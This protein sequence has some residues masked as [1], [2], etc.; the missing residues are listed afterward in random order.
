MNRFPWKTSL[1]GALMAFGCGDSQE[2]AQAAD[3]SPGEAEVHAGQTYCVY[4]GPIIETRFDCPE[5]APVQHVLEGMIIC[6]Q[7]ETLP[8]LPGWQTVEPICE[9]GFEDHCADTSAGFRPATD[10]ADDLATLLWQD[11]PDQELLTA[12][13]NGA[14]NT[15]S[16]V[17][18]QV[19]R[20][21]ADPRSKA[22]LSPFWT[23]YLQLQQ[24]EAGAAGATAF[25]AALAG[26]MLTSTLDTIHHITITNAADTRDL[27]TSREVIVEQDVGAIMGLSGLSTTPTLTTI[28][29]TEDRSGVLSHPAFLVGQTDMN[30]ARI[31]ITGRGIAIRSMLCQDLPP[32]PDV[33]TIP[34]TAT[35]GS[36]RSR[37][38]QVT[39]DP[40]CMGCHALVDFPSFALEGFDATGQERTL[41]NGFSIDKSGELDSA[42]L[43]GAAD[44]GVAMHDDSKLA[45]CMTKKWL[46]FIVNSDIDTPVIDED[47]LSQALVVRWEAADYRLDRLIKDIL[48]SDAFLMVP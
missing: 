8:P 35:T 29:L 9:Y 21:L 33:V 31:A 6:S 47:A 19:S 14:L 28:P 42:L 13:T 10:I 5:F 39:A 46:R 16:G 1:I 20:M 25:D 27:F 23:Q 34:Q 45:P 44:L 17:A 24:L 2:A 22:G 7:G 41:D 40:A 12:A 48:V 32:P 38:S 4:R 3:C 30:Y 11:L 36:M 37:L 43:S 15:R 18:V 26:K